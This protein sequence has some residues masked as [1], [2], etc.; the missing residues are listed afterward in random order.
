MSVAETDPPPLAEP[1]PSTPGPVAAGGYWADLRGD[2]VGMVGVC[3]LV[4][5]LVEGR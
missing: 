2:S 1:P 4:L 3:S 5:L